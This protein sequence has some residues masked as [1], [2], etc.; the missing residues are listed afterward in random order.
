VALTRGDPETAQEWQIAAADELAGDALAQFRAGQIL[1][2]ASQ[3][4]L[5]RARLNAALEASQPNE[6]S[7]R[8][9]ITAKMDE[10]DNLGA[11]TVLQ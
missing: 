9:Q 1:I 11:S 2:A 7:L 4:E 6:I 3:L 8:E 10:I 5:A